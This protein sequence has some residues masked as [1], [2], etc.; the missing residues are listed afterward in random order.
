MSKMSGSGVQNVLCCSAVRLGR[1]F[2]SSL[3]ERGHYNG[4]VCTEGVQNVQNVQNADSMPV[5]PKLATKGVFGKNAILLKMSLNSRS[6]YENGK[7]LCS[8][9]LQ[10]LGVLKKF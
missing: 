5:L 10:S 1:G 7:T 3:S 6:G 9:R 8:T 2:K 4:T